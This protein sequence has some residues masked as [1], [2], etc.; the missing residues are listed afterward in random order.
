[1]K[2]FINVQD[3]KV[4]VFSDEANKK[5]INLLKSAL[6]NKI[7]KGRDAIKKCISTLVSIEIVGCEAILHAYNERDSVALSL[8]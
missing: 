2:V 6:E 1:M 8:Y 3:R 4:L 5:K 7:T